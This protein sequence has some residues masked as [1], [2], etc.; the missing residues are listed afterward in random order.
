MIGFSIQGLISGRLQF[1]GTRLIVYGVTVSEFPIVYYWLLYVNVLL[2]TIGLWYT[3]FPQYVM[4]IK[5]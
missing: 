2:S 3:W 1:A 4:C 5:Y